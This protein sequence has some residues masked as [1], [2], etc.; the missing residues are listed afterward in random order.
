[1][2]TRIAVIG[3]GV[4][5]VGSALAL[6]QTLP[7]A[8]VTIVTAQ[9]TPNTTGDGAAGIWGPHYV[10]GDPQKVRD[11]ASASRVMSG[12]TFHQHE[13]NHGSYRADAMVC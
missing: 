13:M 8:S 12:C 2:S 5:G 10:A 6:Q 1:M 11:G 9:V 4:I 7:E 3:A